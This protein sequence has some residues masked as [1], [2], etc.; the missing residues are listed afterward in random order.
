MKWLL[1]IVAAL[2]VLVGVGV[3]LA[4]ASGNGAI[5]RLAAGFLFGAPSEPFD[6]ALTAPAPD[7]ADP[8]SWA[9]L[10]ESEDLSDREPAGV[11]PRDPSVRP[12]DV[13]FIHPTGYLN[14]ASW[15][16]PMDPDSATEENT[17]W[18]LANQASAYGGCCEVYAPRYREASIFTYLSA[19]PEE[20]EKV[21]RFAYEDV[22]R[23]FDTFLEH[24]SEGRPFILASHSQGTHHGVVLLRE[25]IDG[26]ALAERMV[27]AYLIGGGLAASEFA[28]METG[29][30]DSPT[31][32]GCAVH[33]D[34]MSERADAEPGRAG[35]VCVNPLT[36]KR[37]GALAPASE[38]V[39]GV[40]VS[41][42]FQ[43]DFL[44]DDAAAGMVF[45][46][47][48]APVPQHVS[49]R[50]ADGVLYVTHQEGS[51]FEPGLGLAGSTNY[52]G[53]DYPLF[54]QD[55]RENAILRVN[56]YLARAEAS[57]PSPGTSPTAEGAPR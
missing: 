23:A 54:H 33:W 11:A 10:P 1:R 21:M 12:V 38:H 52:H 27:A 24:H 36:W 39:G 57:E 49:A 14:G 25:R 37:Q 9:A 47:L 43:I 44:G 31:D 16:S 51:V 15:I 2:F 13:F 34:T 40:P 5:I 19:E 4:Y 45:P 56:A 32:L 8:A 42:R 7:Y 3:G 53:L 28:G 26:T 55:I 41:G 50:C 35:N 29:I 20:R 30:C 17:Q 46:P 18:M 6:P 48:A 22:V